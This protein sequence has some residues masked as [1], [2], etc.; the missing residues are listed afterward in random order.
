MIG[1]FAALDALLFYVFW[2]A[3]LV[4][5]FMIIGVWGGARTG[6]RDPQVLPVHL[7]WLRADAGR[8]YLHVHAS[9]VAMAFLAFN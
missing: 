3:M 8:V 7:P 2:E 6:L 9:P 1:V 5:M 4:P